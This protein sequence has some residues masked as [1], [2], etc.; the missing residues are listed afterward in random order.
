MKGVVIYGRRRVLAGVSDP[1]L[2]SFDP[3]AGAAICLVG[4]PDDAR[5]A[6]C[7]KGGELELFC[8]AIDHVGPEALVSFACD[9]DDADFR[10]VDEYVPVPH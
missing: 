10:L 4:V 6:R 5:L 3:R 9:P 7:R 2:D 8:S 1:T